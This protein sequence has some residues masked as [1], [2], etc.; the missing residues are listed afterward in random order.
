MSEIVVFIPECSRGSLSKSSLNQFRSAAKVVWGEIPIP[1][2]PISALLAAFVA[3]EQATETEY[4]VALDT[5]TILLD[6]ISVQGDYDVW[7][8][9]VD[10][11]AQYWGSQ[12]AI[13]DWQTLYEYFGLTMPSQD[14]YIVASVDRR[15]IP[16]YW[17]SGVVVT[18]DRSLPQRWLEYTEAMYDND[19][20]P[21]SRGE[22]FLDQ[23][24]L[25]LVTRQNRVC[26]LD[27]VANYPLG[28]RLRL[29]P[30]VSL[31]HYG[32]RRNLSRVFSQPARDQL[33]AIGAI[34]DFSIDSTIR[35]FLDLASTKSG[36]VFNYKRKKQLRTFLEKRLPKQIIDT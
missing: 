16:P 32:D 4:V 5:D 28:G 13:Y 10:V 33:D 12:D 14:E 6:S 1:E 7:V 19:V 22:F 30:D 3:A 20:L 29:P 34:P 26:K 23:L 21:V 9:P 18:T 31:V 24:S 35:S 15:K 17:N 25:A 36:H 2:Y 11:G 8:R 27:E